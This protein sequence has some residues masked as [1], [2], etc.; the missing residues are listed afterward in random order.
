MT[1][2]VAKLEFALELQKRAKSSVEYVL[3]I[4]T[5]KV[6]ASRENNNTVRVLEI[7]E[8]DINLVPC[9]QE[10]ETGGIVENQKNVLP[11]KKK[12]KVSI[13]RTLCIESSSSLIRTLSEETHIV[14]FSFLKIQVATSSFDAGLVLTYGHQGLVFRGHLD[15]EELETALQIQLQT[16]YIWSLD[17]NDHIGM[18][19]WSLNDNDNDVRMNSWSLNN[20]DTQMSIPN[21]DFDSMGIVR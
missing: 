6:L 17:E 12:D 19:R 14:E 1:D 4:H 18:S 7:L 21:F 11:L 3:P 9:N 5:N 15:C 20:D 2:V 13:G 8:D 16:N 10:D